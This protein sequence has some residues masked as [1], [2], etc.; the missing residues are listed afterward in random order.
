[1]PRCPSLA[2]A[3]D[4]APKPSSK[5]PWSRW[6]SCA[7]RTRRD[8]E[9]QRTRR[10]LFLACNAAREATEAYQQAAEQDA[11][12]DALTALLGHGLAAIACL[13]TTRAKTTTGLGAKAAALDRFVRANT[14]SEPPPEAVALAVAL[15]EDG[16]GVV[17]AMI[18][19]NSAPALASLVLERKA[20]KTGS[21]STRR[22]THPAAQ[23]RGICFVSAPAAV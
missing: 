3:T 18:G 19:L 5:W 6:R 15:V 4:A 7:R 14:G 12:S 9:N 17:K 21:G 13:T 22:N 10:S 1:M 23:W 11:P 20:D 16:I 8:D 2:R